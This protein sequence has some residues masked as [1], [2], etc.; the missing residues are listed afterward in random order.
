M[1]KYL[2]SLIGGLFIILAVVTSY[3]GD[4]TYT[5]DQLN[6]LTS[7]RYAD[8]T[9]IEYIYDGIG[10]RII[11]NITAPSGPDAA[12]TAGPT[13][14]PAPL[15]VAFTDQST[16]DVTSRSWDFGDGENSTAQN[17]Q[18]T[19]STPGVF[20]A[21]LTVSNATGISSYSG[22]IRVGQAKPMADFSASSVSG[23]APLTVSFTD[24]STGEITGWLWDFGDGAT[25]SAQ[26]PDHTYTS[27]GIY[28]AALTVIG[29]GGLSDPKAISITVDAPVA[30]FSASPME[31]FAPLLVQFTDASTGSVTGWLWN[32]GDEQTSSDQNPS[33]TYATEGTY[34]VSLTAFGPAGSNTDTRTGCI[35]VSTP[36]PSVPGIDQY[37]KLLLHGEGVEGA[38]IIADSS[39][40]G[41]M[42]SSVTGVVT[43]AAEK[44]MGAA[45]LTFS[46]GFVR[47]PNSTTGIW[48][49]ARTLP[50]TRG[51]ST[52]T[53]IRAQ[54][55]EPWLIMLNGVSRF[56]TINY[57]FTELMPGLQRPQIPFR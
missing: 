49:E 11:R 31:G 42:P 46:S 13:S 57:A 52:P 35:I 12:F 9:T 26:N 39:V 51:S 41:H 50:S 48:Q 44:K 56:T 33:H 5:Y 20:T 2:G 1:N 43:T 37:T 18:H 25:S 53:G 8:G 55:A 17:P 23:A 45:S 19:Y 28:T 10:N 27:S 34:T 36:P 29:P 7:V 24:S 32:F 21:I 38:S 22:T 54:Y 16:G 14:G 30:D 4:I 15:T 6:R 40:F 47:Y 3:A